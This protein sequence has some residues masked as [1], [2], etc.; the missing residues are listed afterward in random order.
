MWWEW[1]WNEA[2]VA[3]SRDVRPMSLKVNL[4]WSTVL[5]WKFGGELI[6]GCSG[7]GWWSWKMPRCTGDKNPIGVPPPAG[8]YNNV[9]TLLNDGQNHNFGLRSG[10]L[11]CHHFPQGFEGAI[12]GNSWC[13]HVHP[14]D[15]GPPRLNSS[16]FGVLEIA[17]ISSLWKRFKMKKI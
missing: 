6:S 8:L 9:K 14:L 12:H 16:K 11:P 15:F 4:R 7:E 1:R 13:R 3:P 10:A 2:F 5:P 17:T